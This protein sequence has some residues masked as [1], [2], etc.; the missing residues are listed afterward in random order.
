[1][2]S[3]EGDTAR[4]K[5]RDDLVTLRTRLAEV[6][7]M[8]EIR[9]AA[10]YMGSRRARSS[11]DDNRF[12]QKMEGSASSILHRF[13]SIIVAAVPSS[14]TAPTPSHRQDLVE[15]QQFQ[16]C[17]LRS[18]YWCATTG[19]QHHEDQLKASVT[20]GR[21][22]HGVAR[23]VGGEL[24]AFIE[25][26]G[27]DP[28]VAL[29]LISGGLG[30]G[31]SGESVLPCEV[32]SF[33]M[34][35]STVSL[36]GSARRCGLRHR[37]GE[38]PVRPEEA[39]S[40]RRCERID[41]P[42]AYVRTGA[43]G[44][45]TASPAI[46]VIASMEGSVGLSG[47]TDYDKDTVGARKGK[48]EAGK[49]GE[50]EEMPARGTTM[51]WVLLHEGRGVARRVGRPVSGVQAGALEWLWDQNPDP[52]NPK[53]KTAAASNTS[54]G[55][56]SAG[57]SVSLGVCIADDIVNGVVKLGLLSVINL[58]KTLTTRLKDDDETG[59]PEG[60]GQAIAQGEQPASI[61]LQ[62]VPA[63]VVQLHRFLDGRHAD[64]VARRSA[65]P[66]V[67]AWSSP[68]AA[69]RWPLRSARTCGTANAPILIDVDAQLRAGHRPRC[70]DRGGGEG[71][72][73]RRA[74]SL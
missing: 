41:D 61:R 60:V 4:H 37:E 11:F 1:M 28:K 35:G 74:P 14:A 26:Q 38:P 44:S 34:G 52:K 57:V 13:S 18:G 39:A 16:L 19:P 21:K 22:V 58:I 20:G 8:Y 72:P 24:G 51:Y 7:S 45:V 63:G 43:S 67:P 59:A 71:D 48:R 62:G 25:A 29:Q 6:D 42:N 50:A 3:H 66:R 69:C 30:T 2:D 27:K 9:D 40:E 31:D 64:E 53:K 73:S 55:S 36:D 23:D 65:E 5:Q 15:P 49:L 56:M 32:A 54:L 47:G 46:V 17:R 12:I 33:M 68:P 10:L 70:V